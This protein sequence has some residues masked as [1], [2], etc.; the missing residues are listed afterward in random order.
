MRK[1]RFAI[2]LSFLACVG[3]AGSASVARNDGSA[4]PP[5]TTSPTARSLAVT[6]PRGSDQAVNVTIVTTTTTTVVVVHEPKAIPSDLLFAFDSA[7]L[8]GEA[9]PILASALSEAKGKVV[10]IRVDGHTDADGSDAYNRDLSVRRA[11]AVRA[12]FETHDVPP[13]VINVTGWGETR[14]VAPND[15]PENKAK[16][17][18]VEITLKVSR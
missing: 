6:V 2:G 10:S 11:E 8:S 14:P 17:R 7:T 5:S 12:W 9:G 13:G 15:T 18:R 3:C 4:A 16:N 1:N